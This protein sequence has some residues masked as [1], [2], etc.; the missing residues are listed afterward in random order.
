MEQAWNLYASVMK[1][2]HGNC[3]RMRE[4]I[5]G[6]NLYPIIHPPCSEILQSRMI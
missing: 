2:V 5:F 6:N 3:A 1:I 4:H